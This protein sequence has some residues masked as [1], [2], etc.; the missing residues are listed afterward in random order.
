MILQKSA[1]NAVFLL[2]GPRAWRFFGR[3]RHELGAASWAAILVGDC[4]HYPANALIT[5]GFIKI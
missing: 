1:V 4:G 3:G 2:A 5:E